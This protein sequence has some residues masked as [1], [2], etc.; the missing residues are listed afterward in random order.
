MPSSPVH[1]SNVYDS[2]YIWFNGGWVTPRMAEILTRCGQSSGFGTVYLSQGGLNTTVPA[3]AKTHYGL[4][5]GDIKIA[6]KPF[7][8]VW[9]L[10]TH[11]KRSG[12]LPFIRG[13]EKPRPLFAKHIHVVSYPAYHA[14]AQAQNQV[15]EY[16]KS[17]GDGL[18]GPAPY[19]GPAVKLD[20]WEN[21]PYNPHN[22]RNVKRV[23]YVVPKAGLFGLNVDRGKRYTRRKGFKLWSVREVYRWGRWNAVTHFGTYYALSYLSTSKPK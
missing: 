20:T 5:V 18:V 19:Y 16:L 9:Q 11:L 6:G 4:D 8:L 22:I 3:S 10:A 17:H 15:E 13:F 2:D 1:H 21:S 23:L 7:A 12:V 14:H